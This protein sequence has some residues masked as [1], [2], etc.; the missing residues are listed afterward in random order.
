MYLTIMKEIS[1][2]SSNVNHSV[3]WD[4]LFRFLTDTNQLDL[5]DSFKQTTIDLLVKNIILSRTKLTDQYDPYCFQHQLQQINRNEFQ[6][7]LLPSLQK[8][9]L[10][11]PEISLILMV[12]II[13]Y[14]NIDLSDFINDICKILGIHLHS[15]NELLQEESLEAVKILSKKCNKSQAI[16]SALIYFVQIY[17]GSEGKLTVLAHRHTLIK[18]IGHLSF[19]HVD[20]INGKEKLMQ[21]AIEELIKMSKQETVESSFVLIFQQ[22]KLWIQHSPSNLLPDSFWKYIKEFAKSKSSSPP[23][24]TTLYSCLIAAFESKP[25]DYIDKIDDFILTFLLNSA[26]NVSTA[27]TKLPMVIESLYASILLLKIYYLKNDFAEKMKNFLSSIQNLASIT[28]LSD[29]FIAQVSVE[30][31]ANLIDFIVIV[32][33]D[34]KNLDKNNQ[35]FL[36]KA[37]VLLMCHQ[38]KIIRENSVEKFNIFC[39][40]NESFL[41]EIIQTFNDLYGENRQIEIERQPSNNNGSILRCVQTL[42]NHCNQ[43]ED[44]LM[45]NS[46]LHLCHHPI[47]YQQN[48][49]LFI[50]SFVHKRFSNEQIK[51]DEF[52]DRN[53]KHLTQ[54]IF[55]KEFGGRSTTL[56]LSRT[57][58]KLNP[59]RFAEHFVLIIHDDIN[60]HLTEF[61]SITE[62]DFKIFKTPEGH[63][64]NR[65]IVIEAGG[66]QD[67]KNLKRESK[68]YSHKEQL[69]EIQ[70]RKELEEKRKNQEPE[71]DPTKFSKKQKEIYSLEMAK[72][73]KIRDHLQCLY[74]QFLFETDLLATIID[75]NPMVASIHFKDV[76]FTYVNLFA[77]HL[78]IEKAVEFFRSISTKMMISPIIKVDGDYTTYVQIIINTIINLYRSKENA[79]NYIDLVEQIVHY[80]YDR[81]CPNMENYD[82]KLVKKTEHNRLTTPAFT[83]IF[84]LFRFVLLDMNKSDSEHYEK[85][86]EKCLL[87]INEHSKMRC[88]TEKEEDNL[89]NPGNLPIKLILE[90]LFSFMENEDAEDTGCDELVANTLIEVV[91]SVNNEM[92][93]G[94]ATPRDI[95]VLLGYTSHQD[96]LIR[97]TS[98]ESLFILTEQ[99]LIF[100]DNEYCRQKLAHRCFIGQF[101]ILPD[102]QAYS[103]Q[104]FKLCHFKT[105]PLFLNVI[106][107]EDMDSINLKMTLPVAE[108]YKTLL[109][110]FSSELPECYEK[111]IKFYQLKAA[112][113]KPVL[114]NFGR[115]LIKNQVDQYEPRLTVANI[116]EK[117]VHL[118]DGNIFESFINFLIPEALGD[119]NELVRR[120]MLDAGRRCINVHGKENISYLLRSFETFLDS[121]PDDHET[122]IVRESVIILMGTLARHIESDNP[123]LKPILSKLVEALSTPSK[124]VQEAVANCLQYLIPK[125]KDDAPALLQKLLAFLFQS[126]SYGERKGAAY[127]IAGIVKGLGILSINKLGIMDALTQAIQ[128]KDKSNNREGALFAFEMLSRMLGRLFEPYIVHILPHLLDCFGDS[129][130]R[131]RKAADDTAKIIMSNLTAYGVTLIYPAILTALEDDSWRKKTSSIELLGSMAFCAPKQLSQC[132]PK[133]V[134]KLMAVLNDS[135][136]KVQRS[137]AEALKQIGSV[138][139]NPEIQEIVPVLLNALQDPANKTNECLNV[140]MKMK[141]VHVIDPPSLALI[142]PV[143]Q[144]AFQNRSTETRKM[145]SQIVGNMYALAKSKDLS[146][147]LSSI[148][149]GLKNSLLDPVPEVRTATARALGA[150]VR[151]L[152]NEILDDLRPWLERM[153]ISEQ[154]SVDRSGAAQGLAEV[155]GGLGKDHLDKYMPKI[156]EVTENQDVPA[157]VKDGFIMLYI[158]LPSVF[159]QH[160]ASYISRVINPILKALADENEFVRETALRAGQRIVNMY[161]ETAIQLLLPELERGLFNENWRIRYSSVQLLGDL[162]FKITGLSGKM[163]TESQ[164][165]DD[166][167]GTDQSHK[168][169][170][171][172][173]GEER[174]N[175]VLSGLYMGRSDVSLQVRQASLH[176]WKIIVPNTPRTLREILPVLFTLLLECLASNSPDRQQIGA[177]TLGDL[178]RKLG[179]RILPE[180]IPIL[181]DGLKSNRPDQ[182]QGVCIG[183]SEIIVSTSREMIQVFADNFIATV[184]KALFD[185]LPEVR[186]AAAQSF[187]HLHSAIGEK[188][189]SDILN[190]LLNNID[191]PVY[192]ERVLDSLKAIISYKSRVVLPNLIPKLTT[193]PVNTRALSIIAS[194][195]GES[196]SK[197]L[198]LV[199]P[200]LLSSLSESFNNPNFDEQLEYCQNVIVSISDEDGART[201]ILTLL[202]ASKSN[203]LNKKRA[204]IML[205]SYYCSQSKPGTTAE[206]NSTI[207]TNLIDFFASN[208]E[209][210]LSKASEAMAAIIKNLDK[211]QQVE[212]IPEVYRKLYSILNERLPENY[213]RMGAL[214]YSYSPLTS[215]Y[216]YVDHPDFYFPGFLYNKGIQPLLNLFNKAITGNNFEI[217]VIGCNAHRMIVI[218]SSPEA[219]KPSSMILCGSMLRLLCDHPKEDVKIIVIDVL[220]LLLMKMGVFL[221]PFYPQIQMIF[222]RSLFESVKS[223]RLQAATCISRFAPIHPKPDSFLNELLTMNKNCPIEPPYLKETGFFALRLAIVTA[224]ERFSPSIHR[225]VYEYAAEYKEDMTNE[226]QQTAAPLIG[227]LCRVVDDELLDEIGH[228]FLLQDEVNF[229]QHARKFRAIV[230]GIALK[231]AAHRTFGRNDDWSTMIQQNVLSLISSSIP[232]LAVYGIKCAAYIIHYSLQNDLV[233]D[234]NLLHAFAKAMNHQRNEVKQAMNQGTIFW[235]NRFPINKEI[236]DQILLLMVPQLVNGT[237]EK[238]TSVR[239]FA[240]QALISLLKLRERNSPILE[241][242]LKIIGSGAAESLQECVAK[243]K[244]NILKNEFKE[245][246]FDETLIFRITSE[247]I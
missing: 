116:L 86:V 144:R 28:F 50:K 195:A 20:D 126:D 231:D 47:V 197:H 26:K 75:T 124:I 119:Q 83:F 193:K 207:I 146:P 182:R 59:H 205:L 22:M 133:I 154:S 76:L 92:G 45:F 191:D 156:L 43:D 238:N 229:V 88:Y 223:L 214:T 15:K 46:I 9:I 194:V 99:V 129:S 74:E 113:A 4:N 169:L 115:P 23:T 112:A 53:F 35:Q 163:T 57:L 95:F 178:V 105:N 123:K 135:H 34:V 143:I 24:L 186:Q 218:H 228:R 190:H 72:E 98:F 232:Y 91:T 30:N 11:N 25:N 170:F 49:N 67:D 202:D 107:D 12:H 148:I 206:F 17:N 213:R 103:N 203:N 164:S 134:P 6:S 168:A 183:L 240:E 237:K 220:S 139:K 185:S 215:N 69:A 140:M 37:I 7:I 118:F 93:C 210:I 198:H 40:K 104:I 226:I 225:Q 1:R 58:M 121:A 66:I 145:A 222:F 70:L 247:E 80:I 243:I 141:F 61:K 216:Q 236:P 114:D 162:L 54:A 130:T 174:R 234:K 60:K 68:L 102:C 176:V 180:I 44:Q 132:L 71:F 106:L 101:D 108:A 19:A 89:R 87:I 200:P 127:G 90:T 179:E 147:Y 21:I 184:R 181:E 56:N 208:D 110:E 122:D 241:K 41:M 16:E 55:D 155:L 131:V 209:C 142:M 161:A 221:K 166:N 120:A 18:S 77:S 125:F 79:K 100:L 171:E 150:M 111:L 51:I 52:I 211:W 239:A 13:Q 32:I 94:T 188:C 149:P 192:G 14:L 224:G 233:L 10:R 152:G 85:I 62:D 128:A 167:F 84:P 42:L 97:L 82:E 109:E 189:L 65:S 39:E 235:A 199:I 3:L 217:R 153:L 158:Y 138:I 2:S 204:A 78:T 48:Q 27:L 36:Y 33:R 246:E 172:A 212:V 219:L 81:T 173:L 177:R 8:A 230:L 242:C 175:C 159:T 5:I 165:E 29:K 187:D 157:Y 227:A 38:S 73:K 245:E 196:F 160:F 117:I 63:L 244:K 96:D 136:P 151:S 137:A 31:L 201:V 64:Y